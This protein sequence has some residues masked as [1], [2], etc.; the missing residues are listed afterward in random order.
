MPRP[1]C[2]PQALPRR[3]RAARA[4]GDRLGSVCRQSAGDRP[5]TSDALQLSTVVYRR[6]GFH[7]EPLAWLVQMGRH[8]SGCERPPA[9]DTA[10]A[11]SPGRPR[12]VPVDDRHGC[13]VTRRTIYCLRRDVRRKPP[14]VPPPPRRVRLDARAGT[15]GAGSTTFSGDGQVPAFVTAGGELKMSSLTDGLVTTLARDV[16]LLYGIAWAADDQIIFTRAATLWAVTRGG[17][18]RRLTTLAANEQTHA[19]PSV[20]PDGRTLIFTVETAAG[21]PHRGAHARDRRAADGHGPGHE[22]QGRSG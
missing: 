2:Q 1:G 15:I 13:R 21:P 12:I 19:W 5:S 6:G 9:D 8:A 10:G 14:T 4:G 7:R 3:R 17:A 18:P 20:L 11:E 16:S 22:G